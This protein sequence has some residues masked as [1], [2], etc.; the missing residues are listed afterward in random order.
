VDDLARAHTMAMDTNIPAGVYNL[1]TSLGHSNKEIVSLVEKVTGK[2]LQG[3]TFKNYD[4]SGGIKKALGVEWGELVTIDYTKLSERQLRKVISYYLRSQN[5]FK[6]SS[7]EENDDDNIEE[8][9]QIG[10]V[11]P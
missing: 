9:K 8:I 4:R 5:Y 1:G 2:K 11:K 6:P 7:E 10:K 3:V